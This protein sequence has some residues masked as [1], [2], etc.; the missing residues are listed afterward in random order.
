MTPQTQRF[1]FPKEERLNRKR[2]IEALFSGKATSIP[3]FPLRVVYL[4]VEGDYP[5]VS[6]LISVPKKR[7]KR[8][9]KRNRTK[10]LIR[11]AFRK[12]KTMLTDVLE[13]KGQ[14]LIMALIWLDDELREADVV[15][16]KL[17]HLFN[18]MKERMV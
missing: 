6:L 8:A 17:I 18:L 1:T 13:P 9:V 16:A 10:R 3:A 15:E 12:N 5:P 7:F 11:E 14:K 2:L 4:F